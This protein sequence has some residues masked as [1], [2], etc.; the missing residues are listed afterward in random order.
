MRDRLRQIAPFALAGAGAVTALSW[1]GLYS[2]AWNDYEVEAMPAMQALVHRDFARFAALAPAYGGSLLLRSPFALLS[3]VWGGGP[4]AVYQAISVPCLIAGAALGG[5]LAMRM[6]SRGAGMLS[7][8]VTFGLC[9][10]S[11]MTL[12]AL[13]LG[14]ADAL[15]GGCLC[16]AAVLLASEGRPISSGLLLGL[17]VGNGEWAVVAAGPVLLSLPAGASPSRQRVRCATAAVVAAAALLGPIALLSPAF[18]SSTSAAASTSSTIFQ[19]WQ[20]FWFLGVHGP[21][22][23]G[24]FGKVKVG[25]RTAPAWVG[26]ISHPLIVAI[27]AALPLLLY[28]RRRRP[29]A[30]ALLT[31]LMLLRCMLDTWDNAYYT[32]PFLISLTAWDSERLTTSDADRLTAS[33]AERRVQRGGS[34]RVSAPQPALL[35]LVTSVLCWTNFEWLPEHF[36]ADAQAAFFLLWTVPLAGLLTVRLLATPGARRAG[37]AF[38]IP[39]LRRI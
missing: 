36:S 15:L 10:A 31:L 25:Y 33:D 29:D 26:P 38:R 8:W 34:S 4:L 27:G 37:S 28:L 13:E 22:V 7:Q 24:L 1:L 5:C 30:L 23:H 18:V 19:P 12:A 20:L 32:L 17:A 21:A 9:A 14:H 3:N 2:F 6:R 11:P 39:E 16:V 35:A